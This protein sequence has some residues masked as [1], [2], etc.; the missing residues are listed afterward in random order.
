MPACVWMPRGV[1]LF[2][3][4]RRL[5]QARRFSGVDLGFGD[6]AEAEPRHGADCVLGMPVVADRP[7][8]TQHDL[9]DLRIGHVAA[10]EHRKSKF[11]PADGAIAMLDQVTQTVECTHGKRDRRP[12]AGEL[13]DGRIKDERAE[14]EPRRCHA[15]I[16]WH[17][18]HGPSRLPGA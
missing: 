3:D 13:T 11:V 5:R 16:F 6:P 18:E 2:R 1:C 4:D 8:R 12:I 17:A 15:P 7:A 10:A 14:F 9:A